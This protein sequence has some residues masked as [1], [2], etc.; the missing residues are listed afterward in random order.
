M[1]NAVQPPADI[2]RHQAQRDAQHHGEE[3][4]AKPTKS[5]MREP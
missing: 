3:T 2:A 5:E 4:A 1:M